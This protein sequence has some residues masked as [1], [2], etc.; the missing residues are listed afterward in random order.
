MHYFYCSNRGM[1]HAHVQ[2][3]TCVFLVVSA[4]FFN[5]LTIESHEHNTIV[6][7]LNTSDLCLCLN[8]EYLK[9]ELQKII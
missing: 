6:E 9:T 1:L 5:K 3:P 7:L 8:C 4:T 2:P